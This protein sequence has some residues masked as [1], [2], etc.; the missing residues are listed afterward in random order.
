MTLQA[1]VNSLFAHIAAIPDM[2]ASP[3][4]RALVKRESL[5]LKALLGP[6]I[7]DNEALD[8]ALACTVGRQWSIGQARVFVCWAAGSETG[9]TNSKGTV[10]VATMRGERV[11]I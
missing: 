6:V 7:S 2:D 4:T 5:I 10:I 1:V 9:Q 8:C 3:V 11:H